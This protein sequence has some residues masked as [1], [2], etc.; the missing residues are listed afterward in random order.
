MRAIGRYDKDLQQFVEVLGPV[1]LAR[2]RFERW[3]CE[4]SRGEHDSISAPAGDLALAAAVVTNDDLG[5]D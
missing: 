1:N 4:T 2:L 3:L 5:R